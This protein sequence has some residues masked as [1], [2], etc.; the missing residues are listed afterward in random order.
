[1]LGNFFDGSLNLIIALGNVTLVGL[2]T[3]S[4]QGGGWQSLG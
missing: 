4:S 3:A 1:M 2:Y